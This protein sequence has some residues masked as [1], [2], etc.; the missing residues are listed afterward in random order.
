MFS[1]PNK[2]APQHLLAPWP[3]TMGLTSK[4]G[5]SQVWGSAGLAGGRAQRGAP[6][7]GDAHR[8]TPLIAP[9]PRLD[10]CL[11]S[12]AHHSN[13]CLTTPPQPLTP[14]RSQACLAKR[15]AKPGAK[16][17]NTFLPAGKATANCA[18]GVINVDFATPPGFILG[19]ST[20]VIAS[21][22][23]SAFTSMSSCGPRVSNSAATSVTTVPAAGASA[24]GGLTGGTR[25]TLSSSDW[26]STCT[27]KAT[28]RRPVFKIDVPRVLSNCTS[29]GQGPNIP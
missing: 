11:L 2:F 19:N 22:G 14:N 7:A 17:T 1:R 20:T 21:C 15:N 27:C 24:I 4:V 6:A 3:V 10:S 5:G 12:C 28:G 16:C 13:P 9:S 25:V 26:D 23:A 18:G 8:M 29:T